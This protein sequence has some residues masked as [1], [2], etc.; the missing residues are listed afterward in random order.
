MPMID[1]AEIKPASD[2][3]QAAFAAYSDAGQAY[4]TERNRHPNDAVALQRA[5]EAMSCTGKAYEDSKFALSHIVY[6]VVGKAERT[7]AS[8]K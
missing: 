2:A 6:Q 8:P 3:V 4:A 7:A 1:I 5:F